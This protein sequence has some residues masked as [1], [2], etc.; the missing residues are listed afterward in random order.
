MLALSPE[1]VLQTAIEV[2]SLQQRLLHAFFLENAGVADFKLLTDFPKSGVLRV[3]GEVWT[4]A[5]H[6]LGYSFSSEQGRVMD[7]HNH[8]GMDS[9]LVDAHRLTEYLR[10]LEGSLA[11]LE[12][13]YSLVEDGL[14]TLQ[15]QGFIKENAD[16]PLAW[17]LTL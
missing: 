7:V 11:E 14:V 13:L 2:E 16:Q 9:R 8:F 10:S 6:G 17:E 5:K 12:D 15:Q 3:D 1:K 4:Y